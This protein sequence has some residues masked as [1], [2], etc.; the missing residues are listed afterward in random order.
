MRF[1]VRIASY[2]GIVGIPA[3]IGLAALILGWDLNS[4]W[5][6]LVWSVLG[7]GGSWLVYRIWR[8]RS[9]S[10]R[11]LGSAALNRGRLTHR[12]LGVWP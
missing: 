8:A 1:R 11:L 12:F 3:G 7:F 6:Y 9:L 5:D 10:G 4:V 2:M